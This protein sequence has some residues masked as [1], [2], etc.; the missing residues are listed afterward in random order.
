MDNSGNQNIK[1]ILSLSGE[2]LGVLKEILDITLK[3]RDEADKAYQT[4][5]DDGADGAI[6]NIASF[7]D[8]RE[9]LIEQIRNIELSV[10]HYGKQQRALEG[11]AAALEE[12]EKTDKF[13]STAAEI[14]GV[15]ENIRTADDEGSQKIAA[16]M[17][18]IKEKIKAVKSNHAIM[19][20][21]VGD[22][23]APAAGTLL[24]EKK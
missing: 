18:V 10:K 4:D 1:S 21:Y 11:G 6:E 20:R 23:E 16:V 13:I 22:N 7:V 17:A 24:N 2:K 12:L 8:S 5:D 3:I 15:L 9:E 14:S 19:D